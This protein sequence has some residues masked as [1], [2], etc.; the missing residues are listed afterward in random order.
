MTA[1]VR[2]YARPEALERISIRGHAVIEASAGTGK[3]YALEHMVLELLLVARSPIEQILAVT[4]TEKASR[5]LSD[6][7]RSKLEEILLGTWSDAPASVPDARCWRIDEP[8]RRLVEQALFSFDTANIST[9][10]SFCQRV[11]TDHAFAHRRLFDQV[12][13]A[14][15]EAFADAFRMALREDFA[16]DPNL[17]PWLELWLRKAQ[18][19]DA[20]EKLLLHCSR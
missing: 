14:E 12:Q 20:L 11:L 13:I 8:A 5:E 10:H 19:I 2:R 6:R 16:R 9:I 7:V 1:A 15:G 3:T 17:R 4:F 18:S